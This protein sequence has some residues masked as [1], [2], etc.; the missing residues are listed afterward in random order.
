MKW[1]YAVLHG[2]KECGP[3]PRLTVEGRQQVRRLMTLIPEVPE[4]VISG[5]GRR[6]H[7]TCEVLEFANA[8]STP[9]IGDPTSLEVID[10]AKVI[11][12]ADGTSAPVKDD[13]SITDIALV[14]RPFV[15]GL[16]DNTV[17]CTGRPFL[18]ALGYAEAKSGT[19]VRITVHDDG[20]ITF[21]QL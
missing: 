10:G 15:A 8:T 20:E 9:L 17:L 12:F 14:A 21:N 18:L 6:H 16:K 1:I 5:T 4:E 13:R 19:A 11:I 3:D 7:E 2:E